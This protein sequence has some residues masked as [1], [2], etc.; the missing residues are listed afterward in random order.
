LKTTRDVV[1]DCQ[2][3]DHAPVILGEARGDPSATIVTDEC[4][5]LMAEMSRDLPDVFRHVPLVVAK[6]RLVGMAIPA[7]IRHDHVVVVGQIG[8]LLA[9]R[10]P[11]LG[12]AMKQDY[13]CAL[14]YFGDMHANSINVKGMALE[15]RCH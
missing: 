2:A 12:V 4:N 14:S 10:V 15:S 5:A 11:G 9:P 3:L 13:G 7:Q 1:Q 6:V 8:P